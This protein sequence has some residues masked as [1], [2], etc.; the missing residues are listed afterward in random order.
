M[1]WQKDRG[2]TSLPYIY[3]MRSSDSESTQH[4]NTRRTSTRQPDNTSGCSPARTWNASCSM[5]SEVVQEMVQHYTHSG[6][7][8]ISLY[9]LATTIEYHCFSR[10]KTCIFIPSLH[11]E[12]RAT[13][14]HQDTSSNMDTSTTCHCVCRLFKAR[15]MAWG[16][17]THQ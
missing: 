17:F 8:Y 12:I 3:P 15:G 9:Q 7:N 13:A 14:R 16:P 6:T 2:L 10:L 11:S 1:V 4:S 5:W